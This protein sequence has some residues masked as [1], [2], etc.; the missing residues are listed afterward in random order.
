[1]IDLGSGYSLS[2]D[3]FERQ[4]I[5]ENQKSQ[6]RT[7]IYGN[8][9]MSVASARIPE[10][11]N[12]ALLPVQTP[13]SVPVLAPVPMI[14]LAPTDFVSTP[15]AAEPE[16]FSLA[17][18]LTQPVL[19]PAAEP[20]AVMPE[21]VVDAA[22]IVA[23]PEI[24]ALPVVEAVAPPV[25]FEAHETPQ[26]AQPLA[27]AEQYTVPP[28]QP[29]ARPVAF[30]VSIPDIDPVAVLAPIL[31]PMIADNDAGR[32]IEQP[33]KPSE[34]LVVPVGLVSPAL[35]ETP[36][37]VV[38]APPPEFWQFWGT[39]SFVFGDDQ[40]ITLETAPGADGGSNRW[41]DKITVTSGTS[42]V[43]ITGVAD[44]TTG[45]VKIDA[46]SGYDA[47]EDTRDGLTLEELPGSTGWQDEDGAALSQIILDAT[48]A[49]ADFGPGSTLMSRAEI[50][51][52]L[53]RIFAYGFVSSL[54]SSAS[55]VRIN[56]DT[57]SEIRTDT[58][59]SNDR[60]RVERLFVDQ[61]L[62]QQ[63]DEA[64]RFEIGE[65]VFAG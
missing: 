13:V 62:A 15:S 30:V 60:R 22:V 58:E 18:E 23:V 11:S 56:T 28:E 63:A 8:A 19:F 40:K 24:A 43:V 27:A 52:V 5:L 50:T 9:K 2:I 10:V 7:I 35:V 64:R 3:D 33:T 31:A 4:V 26:P 44:G 12:I 14:V 38:T 29:L 39:T 48:A 34:T 65:A 45:A 37:L 46:V 20:A 17:A 49:G 61:I 21:T 36:T 41:L 53:N 32:V 54:M 47:D 1:M 59:K 51:T 57:S 16:T 42:G 6:L 55:L 25:I